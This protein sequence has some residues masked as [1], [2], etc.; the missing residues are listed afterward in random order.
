MTKNTTFST[1]SKMEAG[2]IPTLLPQ[3]DR[4]D[5]IN[6]GEQGLIK[7][8]TANKNGFNNG[9]PIGL[10][11]RNLCKLVKTVGIS[12]I[13][14]RTKFWL[15]GGGSAMNKQQFCHFYCKQKF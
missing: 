1:G 9:A 8:C 6:G 7:L 11:I 3:S 12:R 2:N 4:D 5:R 15:A 14:N 13:Q 10:N